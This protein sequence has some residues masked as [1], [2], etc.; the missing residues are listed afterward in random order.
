MVSS[1]SDSQGSTLS[2]PGTSYA[3]E[4]EDL[5]NYNHKQLRLTDFYLK[6]RPKRLHQKKSK[7]SDTAQR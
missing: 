6:R 5:K 3:A 2:D 7:H 4:K 1:P